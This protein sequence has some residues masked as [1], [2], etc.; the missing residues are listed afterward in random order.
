MLSKVFLASLYLNIASASPFFPGPHPG[1]PH[2]A[3]GRALYI[4][5]NDPAGNNIIATQ[6]SNSDGKLSNPVK[7]PTGGKG[8]ARLIAASQDSVVVSGNVRAALVHASPDCR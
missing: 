2:G 3:G 8:L 6:V 7:I 1:Q 4:Q 5:D